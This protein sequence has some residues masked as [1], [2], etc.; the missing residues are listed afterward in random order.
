MRKLEKETLRC[1]YENHQK[2][3]NYITNKVKVEEKKEREKYEIDLK[4]T[5]QKQIQQNLKNAQN[6]SKTLIKQMQ[7]KFNKNK[8]EAR[9]R[10]EDG[11]VFF[12]KYKDKIMRNKVNCTDCKKNY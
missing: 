3:K 7:E 6:M 2:K 5:S 10:R 11:G 9:Q 1:Q 12:N 8:V 4:I